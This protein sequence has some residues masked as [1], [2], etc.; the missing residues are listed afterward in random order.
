[1]VMVNTYG[2]GQIEVFP[3]IQLMSNPILFHVL[4]SLK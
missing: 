3:I 1:M 4:N 2:S